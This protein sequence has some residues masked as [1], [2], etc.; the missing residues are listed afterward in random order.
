M[1]YRILRQMHLFLHPMCQVEG[2][3]SQAIEIHHTKGRGINLNNVESF[4]SVCRGCHNLIHEH[5][6][7]ARK[8]GLLLA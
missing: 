5:P 3:G 8:H 1:K 2:C 6:L 4:L 7:W